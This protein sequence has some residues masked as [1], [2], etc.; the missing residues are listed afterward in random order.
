MPIGKTIRVSPETYKALAEQ[1]DLSETFDTVIQKL[2]LNQQGLE[3][4]KMKE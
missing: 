3:T 2:I 4:P 1:G